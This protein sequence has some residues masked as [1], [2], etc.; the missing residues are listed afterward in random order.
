MYYFGLMI[1][2]FVY[3]DASFKDFL[4]NMKKVVINS[5]ILFMYVIYTWILVFTGF[6]LE[7]FLERN[8]YIVG[9]FHSQLFMIFV[10]FI[11]FWIDRIINKTAAK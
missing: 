2:R 5:P 4:A 9:I 7:Y 6:K 8:Y 10:V 1:G 11:V 3:F